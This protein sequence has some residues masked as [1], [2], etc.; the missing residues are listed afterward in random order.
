[1]FIIGF[2]IP[3]TFWEVDFCVN[4]A[5][6]D[7]VICRDIPLELFIWGI[8][9]SETFQIYVFRMRPIILS[10]SSR[11]LSNWG[12]FHPRSMSATCIIYSYRWLGQINWVPDIAVVI[13]FLQL[14]AIKFKL[15]NWIFCVR[16][17]PRSKNRFASVEIRPSKSCNICWRGLLCISIYRVRH[18]PWR[19]IVPRCTGLVSR[20]IKT[21]YIHSSLHQF[22][23][24]SCTIPVLLD[25]LIGINHLL[26]DKCGNPLLILG[27]SLLISLILLL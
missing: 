13:Q 14:V 16:P 25:N 22:S 10:V 7:V 9:I 3:K 8:S 19:I 21:S 17:W 20:E 12:K 15:D 27:Y 24:I 26:F 18:T 4:Y 6:W 23:V 2:S 11:R 1:M 5:R